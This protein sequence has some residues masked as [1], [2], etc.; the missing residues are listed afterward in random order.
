M[1][2]ISLIF[3]VVLCMMLVYL[4]Q[5]VPAPFPWVLY[6]IAALVILLVL[7]RVL[8]FDMGSSI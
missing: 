5:H 2:L 3:V 4:G 1:T 8:G 6:A 7:L